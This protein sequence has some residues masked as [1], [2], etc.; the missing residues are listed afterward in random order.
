MK[1]TLEEIRKL[2][3]AISLRA[4]ANKYAADRKSGLFAEVSEE[5]LYEA[6]IKLVTA[7]VKVNG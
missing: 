4:C 3:E 7:L 2:P 6:A 5:K 1:Y